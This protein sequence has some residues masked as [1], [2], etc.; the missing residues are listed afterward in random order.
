MT[1]MT[2]RTMISAIFIW[3]SQV[4]KLVA[5]AT[6]RRKPINSKTA[7]PFFAWESVAK[8]QKVATASALCRP[9]GPCMSYFVQTQEGDRLNVANAGRLPKPPSPEVPRRTKDLGCAPTAE[10]F[11]AS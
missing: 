5:L 2:T 8:V 11:N 3:V 1:V 7:A 9:R 4:M 6:G 10:V